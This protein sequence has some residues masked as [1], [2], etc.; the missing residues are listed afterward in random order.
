[1]GEPFFFSQLSLHYLV[2]SVT[3]TISLS[4]FLQRFGIN[5]LGFTIRKFPTGKHQ[6]SKNTKGETLGFKTLIKPSQESVNRH[7]EK[8]GKI[9]KFHKTSKQLDLIEEL[10]PVIRGWSNYSST[11]VSSDPFSKLDN[12]LRHILKRWGNRR[13]PQ[14]NRHW[15]VNKYW[16]ADKGGGWKFASQ[17]QESIRKLSKLTSIQGLILQFRW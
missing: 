7:K 11:V 17:A 14:K 5:F 6:A 15:V 13:H 2:S 4:S 1:M 16:L 9:I 8:L 3:V 12:W 10:N